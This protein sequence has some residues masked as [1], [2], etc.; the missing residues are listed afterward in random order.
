MMRRVYDRS[1]GGWGR[2]AGIGLSLRLRRFCVRIAKAAIQ[3][4]AGRRTHAAR[5]SKV[6][7]AQKAR[8]AKF[9]QFLDSGP[10][11]SVRRTAG[12]S[13]N[14]QVSLTDDLC[15]CL[16][17]VPIR[18]ERKCLDQCYAGGGCILN[19]SSPPKLHV[20]MAQSSIWSIHVWSKLMSEGLR[21]SRLC[22]YARSRIRRRHTSG[23]SH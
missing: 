22:S 10:S 19:S 16:S 21:P 17:T 7:C 14:L 8:F 2:G 23:C 1:V 20:L 15:R 5:R 4:V 18:S 13:P 6:G 9:R 11:S 3:A 12:P